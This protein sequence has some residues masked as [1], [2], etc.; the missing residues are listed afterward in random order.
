MGY[1][2]AN[3]PASRSSGRE[4]THSKTRAAASNTAQEWDRQQVRQRAKSRASRAYKQKKAQAA[5]EGAAAVQIEQVLEQHAA[6]LS[7][8]FS[9]YAFTHHS[10]KAAAAAAAGGD[11]SPDKSP[12][13]AGGSPGGG[14]AGSPS[15]MDLRSFIR[16]CQEHTLCF[17]LLSRPDATR[18]FHTSTAPSTAAKKAAAAGEDKEDGEAA[19]SDSLR[20]L[21]PV[22]GG[23]LFEKGPGG[24]PYSSHSEAEASVP[25][26]VLMTFPAFLEALA[27][28][29]LVLFSEP[30]FMTTCPKVWVLLNISVYIQSMFSVKV[31]LN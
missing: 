2:P 31:S 20:A 3:S 5:L 18:I 19:A 14:A 11:S 23:G 6:A 17:E 10:L 8:L 29:A 26:V 16:F 21:R 28:A 7:K 1:R 15:G 9:R 12:A 30:G 25:E 13:A 4:S 27:R 24:S 22:K